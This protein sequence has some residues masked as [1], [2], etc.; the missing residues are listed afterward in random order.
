MTR[1]TLVAVLLWVARIWSIASVGLLCV[2][3]IG[4]G[5]P[6]L[7]V[8]AMLFPFGVMIGLMLAWRFERIGGLVAAM[9]MLLFYGLEYLGHGRFPK[10]YAFILVSAPS[11]IFLCCGYLKTRQMSD[12]TAEPGG[13]VYS[14]ELGGSENE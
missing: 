9:S 5:L 13:R 2:F 7:T 11:L 14:G 6:P 12:T 3:L 1:R 10:G 4:E 8:K